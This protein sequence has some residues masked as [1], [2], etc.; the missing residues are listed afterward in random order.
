MRLALNAEVSQSKYFPV[1]FP[2]GGAQLCKLAKTSF[3]LHQETCQ[4]IVMISQYRPL[5]FH[6]KTNNIFNKKEFLKY[7][8]KKKTL[9]GVEKTI[10]CCKYDLNTL[11]VSSDLNPY[12][13]TY[14]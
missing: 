1:N 2:R 5:S 12:P 14:I 3:L 9:S 11:K 7:L 10:F 8:K 6:Y 13:E 4:S